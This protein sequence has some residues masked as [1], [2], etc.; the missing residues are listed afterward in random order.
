MTEEH[1]AVLEA[2]TEHAAL[3]APTGDGV[4]AVSARG[5]LGKLREK[6]VTRMEWAVTHSGKDFHMLYRYATMILGRP[7][8]EVV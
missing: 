7:L 4:P 8:H 2:R 3:P 1:R 5:G 6:D